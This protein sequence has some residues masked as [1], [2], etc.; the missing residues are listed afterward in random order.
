MQESYY[1][2]GPFLGQTCFSYRLL[3]NSTRSCFHI[4]LISPQLRS[5]HFSIDGKIVVLNKGRGTV[6]SQEG[7]GEVNIFFISYMP[8]LQENCDSD[9]V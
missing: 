6:G 5:R 3:S 8:N 7:E 1:Q 9:R 4:I 2:L